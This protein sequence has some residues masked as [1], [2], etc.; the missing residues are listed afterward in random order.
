MRDGHP[1]TVGHFLH[2]LVHELAHVD[3]KIFLTLR[4]LVFQ[5]GKLTAEY[6]A[7]RVASWV[8][9]IR[10]FLVIVALQVLISPGQGPLNH[11]VRVERSSTGNLS[12]TIAG[13]V[14]QFEEKEERV[15]ASEE[16]L[17]E[18][19]HKFEKAYAVVRYSS[20][21]VF[22]AVSWLLYRRRQPYFVSHLVAGLHFYSF[23]YAIALLASLPARMNPVWN[24][25]TVLSAAY[26]FLALRRLFHE[27]WY[28]VLAKTAA[29][30]F[31][32]FAAEFGLGYGV[33]SWIER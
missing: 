3:G 25:L 8:R 26:L 32:V 15:P 24:N 30:Y 27:R 16:E 12:V 9:P 2:D 18:F 17:R 33:A 6:W 23:W 20:V 5:P 1:P 19:S 4:A 21:L 29:L 11:Q 13:D 31:L 7:G 10:I 22:A 14:R 28:V